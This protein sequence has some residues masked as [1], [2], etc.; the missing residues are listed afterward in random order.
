M[1]HCSG[2]SA[3]AVGRLQQS[4]AGAI[5]GL[6]LIHEDVSV[7]HGVGVVL[8]AS[9]IT[10]LL[11]NTTAPMWQNSVT[12]PLSAVPINIM[13]YCS[14]KKALSKTV[15]RMKA[16]L[17]GHLGGSESGLHELLS[18]GLHKL[19]I[20]EQPMLRALHKAHIVP[21]TPGTH[22]TQFFYWLVNNKIHS[23]FQG[24]LQ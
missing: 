12:P 1:V 3:P 13:Q 11:K 19:V 5:A 23:T 16:H 20:K 22:P 14:T 7:L 15:R 17:S 10:M 24:S 4:L 8:Q 9:N 6:A 21:C 18:H 2:T